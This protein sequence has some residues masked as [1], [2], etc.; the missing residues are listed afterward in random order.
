MSQSLQLTSPV[1]GTAASLN[2]DQA[3]WEI[4]EKW[5]QFAATQ[6][7]SQYRLAECINAMELEYVFCQIDTKSRN[8]HFGASHYQDGL[9]QIH[10]GPLCGQLKEGWVHSIC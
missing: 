1:V 8:F 3:G 7:L 4:S 10:R 5:Q 6:A 2:A 9:S